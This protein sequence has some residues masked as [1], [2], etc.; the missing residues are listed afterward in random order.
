ME[1]RSAEPRAPLSYKS[2]GL[3]LDVY[4]QTLAGML[5]Y[6]RRTHTPR[7]LD[8]FG[9]FASLFSLDYNTRLFARNYRH[10]VLV[11]CTD[12]VGSKLKIASLT[13]KHDTV[14]SV[15]KRYRV[16]ASQVAQWNGVA[17]SVAVNI[18]GGASR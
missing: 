5:P 11:S 17:P 14:A 8:G 13:G 7:V 4:E 6:L 18:N 9:G 1:N 3:D 2:A 12:G 15:A 10:P 16:S